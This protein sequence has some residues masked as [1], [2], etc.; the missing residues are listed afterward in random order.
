MVSWLGN[1]FYD[2]PKPVVLE[3]TFYDILETEVDAR[4]FLSN[5]EV[6]MKELHYIRHKELGH[7]FGWNPIPCGEA[8]DTHTHTHSASHRRLVQSPID[9]QAISSHCLCIGTSLKPGFECINRVYSPFGI[10]PTVTCRV[11]GVLVETDV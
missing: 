6:E 10:A 1:Y 4:Y 5:Q 3:K 7:G 2:F 9:R 11:D 8:A